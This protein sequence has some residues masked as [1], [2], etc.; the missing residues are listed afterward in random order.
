MQLLSPAEPL[1][2]IGHVTRTTGWHTHRM[3][4]RSALFDLYGD[5]LRTRGNQAPVAAIVRLLAPVGI[6]APAVRTAISRMVMQGWLEPVTVEGGRGYRATSR[7][8][9][10]LD[11]AGDRIYGRHHPH[12]DGAWH[13]AF[14]DPPATRSA[15]GR[16]RADLAFLGYAE[17][18]DNVWVSPFARGELDS[19]LERAGAPRAPPVPSTSTRPP[20]TPGIST[21]S[22]RRTTTG[23]P[24]PTACSPG[25]SSST[26]TDE[27]AFAGRF[28][29][30]HEWRKFLFA[31]PGLP[32]QLLPQDWPGRGAAERSRRRRRG[33]GRAPTGSSRVAW[34]TSPDDC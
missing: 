21:S 28:H 6:A 20:R 32:E 26:E 7:A 2:P 19:V 18:A 10:R 1:S 29:L 5:H 23:W 3:H 13:L 11:E 24:T 25:T 17:L 16:L 15:R 14:V 8:K 31:D 9:R 22:A 12:W 34:T 30:V 33:W 4:A 27:A